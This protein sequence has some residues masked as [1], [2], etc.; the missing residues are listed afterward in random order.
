M[1]PNKEVSWISPKYCL[2]SLCYTLLASPFTKRLPPGKS[3]VIINATVEVM[4]RDNKDYDVVAED[5]N[6]FLIINISLTIMKT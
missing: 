6:G 5:I 2:L 1:F 3:V 4:D